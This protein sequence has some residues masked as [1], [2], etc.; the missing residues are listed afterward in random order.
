MY[1]SMCNLHAGVVS[2]GVVPEVVSGVVIGVVM[3]V[4]DI[5]VQHT[6]LPQQPLVSRVP[7]HVSP[8]LIHV[9]PS[10]H[11][12]MQNKMQMN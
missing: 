12:S 4:E 2:G 3:G 1:L 9:E 6:L 10:A 11:A 5:G 7:L 8:S